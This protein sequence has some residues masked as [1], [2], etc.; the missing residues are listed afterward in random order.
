MW[1]VVLFFLQSG[2]ENIS[3]F[4]SGSDLYKIKEAEMKNILFV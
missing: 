2:N 3:L 1:H 4:V